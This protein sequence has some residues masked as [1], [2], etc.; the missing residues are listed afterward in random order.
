MGGA[1][2]GRKRHGRTV[3]DA[4]AVAVRDAAFLLHGASVA[5]CRLANL[6][7]QVDAALGHAP[8]I[9]ILTLSLVLANERKTRGE[10]ASIVARRMLEQHGIE[11]LDWPDEARAVVMLDFFV[12]P[13]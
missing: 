3:S 11:L 6:T 4:H 9:L 13:P 10:L 7:A 5:A 1:P 8:D 2:G 12:P